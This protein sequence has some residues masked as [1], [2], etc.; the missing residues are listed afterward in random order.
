MNL[1]REFESD[2]LAQMAEDG[3]GQGAGGVPDDVV[4]VGHAR[5]EEVLPRLDGASEGQAEQDCEYVS[6]QRRP[7]DG[8]QGDEEKEAKGNEQQNVRHD[9]RDDYGDDVRRYLS[10]R[11]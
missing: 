10:P 6:L 3:A 8:V 7:L 11:R 2:A 1:S 4:H 9:R 5:G